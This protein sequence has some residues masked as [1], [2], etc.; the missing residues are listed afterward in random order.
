MS[1][2]FSI[3]PWAW[4]VLHEGEDR[5]DREWQKEDPET[6]V[7]VRLMVWMQKEKIDWRAQACGGGSFIGRVPVQD[8]GRITTWLADA[9]AKVR[10]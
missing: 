2:T 9:G 10:A 8:V 3:E 7:T 4:L 6:W 5:D 1:A